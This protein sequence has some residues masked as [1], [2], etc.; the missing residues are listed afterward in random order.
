MGA[1]TWG[2]CMEVRPWHPAVEKQRGPVL[3]PV[4]CLSPAQVAPE[5][6]EPARAAPQ[7][8]QHLPPTEAAGGWGGGLY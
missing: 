2:P 8:F 5:P 4:P 3:P 6:G 1:H 7:V